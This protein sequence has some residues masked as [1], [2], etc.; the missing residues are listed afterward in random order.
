L[1]NGV[2]LY[3]VINVSPDSLNT[4]SI[5]T[6]VPMALSRA[7]KLLANGCH[8]FDVG[9]QGSTDIAS[10]V[11]PEE[12]WDRAHEIIPA[13][14]ALGKPLS[15]DTWK[16]W[17]ARQALAAGAT[18]LNAADGLQAEG[19]MEVA[20]EFGC[21]V[22]LPYLNGPD[23]R[24]LKHVDGDPLEAMIEWF[25][26]RLREADAFGIRKNMILDPGTGFAPLAWEWASRY[27][28]QKHVYSGLDR[29][30]VFDLPLYIALPWKV[31]DQHMELLEIVIKQQVEYGRCHYPETVMATSDR[32]G[33]PRHQ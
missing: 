6:D 7:M 16:P 2:F 13:L 15:I 33:I 25:D 5:A 32:L 8:G 19:M 27:H 18:V 12:E 11:P 9:A 3:G 24:S 1:D 14:A 4:D 17:V 22:V 26:I 10:I 20:A 30:R 31:T 21:P 23:P 28:F 29:L